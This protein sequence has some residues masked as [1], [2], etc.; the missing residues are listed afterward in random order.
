MKKNFIS[1][2]QVSFMVLVAILSFALS[3]CS[4]DD[5]DNTDDGNGR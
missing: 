1:V 5:D 3:A 2:L 4:N